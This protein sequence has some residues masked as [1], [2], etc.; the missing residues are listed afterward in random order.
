MFIQKYL[1][2]NFFKKIYHTFASG[3][4]PLSSGCS[5]VGS[6][7]G[8]KGVCYNRCMLPW[9]KLITVR[10]KS[11]I[12]RVRLVQVQSNNSCSSSGNS[13]SNNWQPH[14]MTNRS[15]SPFGYKKVNRNKS[16]NF[17]IQQQHVATPYE[18]MFPFLES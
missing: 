7:I 5:Q 9:I 18:K 17:G 11:G 8:R 13:S 14:H 1:Y 16:S 3:L 15:P 6:V 4:S 10:I 12:L 2:V